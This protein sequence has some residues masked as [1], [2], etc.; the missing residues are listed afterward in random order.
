MAL[1]P[2]K[3]C[4]TLNSEN[5]EICLSCEYPIHGRRRP[6]I[7]Q[8]AAIIL[9]ILLT[10]PLINI[11]LQSLRKKPKPQG[12]LHSIAFKKVMTFPAEKT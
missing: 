12:S 1:I 11:A 7:F 5:A 10:A 8:W 9:F 3:V 4:G 2:C 6:V